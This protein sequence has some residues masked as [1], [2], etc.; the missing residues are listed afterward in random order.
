[1][2]KLTVIFMFEYF[3]TS[4]S[5]SIIDIFRN[6]KKMNAEGLE[7]EINWFYEEEDEDMLESG[8][9]Y[10]ELVS[11]PVNLIEIEEFPK[12]EIDPEIAA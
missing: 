9:D 11:M 2:P 1:M 5:R 12:I 8:E 3:N 7:V 6:L 10:S 4:S